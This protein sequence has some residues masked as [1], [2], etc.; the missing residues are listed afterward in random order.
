MRSLASNESD[1]LSPRLAAD[2]DSAN[3]C[4]IR[5]K[6]DRSPPAALTCWR[7]SGVRSDPT[8][9]RRMPSAPPALRCAWRWYVIVDPSARRIQST[10]ATAPPCAKADGLMP[11][12]VQQSI[13]RSISSKSLASHGERTYGPSGLMADKRAHKL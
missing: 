10:C 13:S 8:S 2:L 9:D 6:V 1:H 5:I 7:M 3:A 12:C 11:N 4:G